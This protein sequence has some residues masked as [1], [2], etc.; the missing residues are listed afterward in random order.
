MFSLLYFLK[1]YRVSPLCQMYVLGK[2]YLPLMSVRKKRQIL[3]KCEEF[4]NWEQWMEDGGIKEGSQ[5]HYL[6]KSVLPLFLLQ[7]SLAPN[8]SAVLAKKYW[9]NPVFVRLAFWVLFS[10]AVTD[11]LWAQAHASWVPPLSNVPGQTLPGIE[12]CVCHASHP[13]TCNIHLGI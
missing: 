11:A 7:I 10:Q 5:R 9:S 3:T 1:N 6:K 4:C 8:I 2:I 13:E 12:A